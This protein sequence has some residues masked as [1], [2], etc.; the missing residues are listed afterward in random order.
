MVD[1]FLRLFWGVLL[2]SNALVVLA[3]SNED[4]AVQGTTETTQQITTA[5]LS[6]EAV[7]DYNTFV[8]SPSAV[9]VLNK[10]IDDLNGF[11]AVDSV[12][13]IGHTDNVGS[14]KYNRQLSE[15]RAR[16]I[17]SF[18]AKRFPHLEVS[19]VG[20]GESLPIATNE[21][22]EGRHRNRRVEIQVIAR[23]VKP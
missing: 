14:D 7:F 16:F 17:A 22:A 20:A 5:V 15:K 8:L 10:L 4:D 21:T 6:G 19:A 2:V 23:G 3:Q 12:K 11:L 18:F 1:K 9:T 13:I